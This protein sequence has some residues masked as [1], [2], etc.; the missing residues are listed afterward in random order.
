MDELTTEFKRKLIGSPIADRVSLQI[1]YT[2]NRCE[3]HLDGEPTAV[4]NVEQLRLALSGLR[5]YPETM[6]R[7]DEFRSLIQSAAAYEPQPLPGLIAEEAEPVFSRRGAGAV[8]GSMDCPRCGKDAMTLHGWLDCFHCGYRPCPGCE[9]QVQSGDWWCRICGF[10]G[11]C[12]QC[13]H[14]LRATDPLEQPDGR[15][16]TNCTFSQSIGIA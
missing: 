1:R 6:D 7:T 5:S 14:S 13:G 10:A 16:C 9:A 8:M 15:R 12:E 4:L 11:L 2:D 3:I